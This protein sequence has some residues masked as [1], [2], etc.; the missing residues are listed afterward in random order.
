MGT[1]ARQG[2][3]SALLTA[4][5]INT[6]AGLE[7]ALKA[8]SCKWKTSVKEGV[9]YGAAGTETTIASLSGSGTIGGV[10]FASA[11]A[12]ANSKLRLRI[13]YDGETTPRFDCELGT[14]FGYI[15]ADGDLNRDAWTEHWNAGLVYG[16]RCNFIL[17]LPTSFS[18]GAVVKLYRPGSGVNDGVYFSIVRYTPTVTSTL[19][20]SSTQWDSSSNA[21]SYGYV[22]ATTDFLTVARGKSGWIALHILQCEG[23]DSGGSTNLLSYLERDYQI[24]LGAGTFDWT[25]S[26]T[27]DEFLRSYYGNPDMQPGSVPVQN[28]QMYPGGLPGTMNTLAASY[29]YHSVGAIG[30][31]A[32]T[33]GTA[34]TGTIGTVTTGAGVMNGQYRIYFINSGATADFLVFAPDGVVD[35]MGKVG[36]AYSGQLGFTISDGGTHFSA[37][38]GWTIQIGEAAGTL[39]ADAGA[40]TYWARDYLSD[41]GGLRFTNGCIMRWH[42]DGVVTATGCHTWQ[43][44]L[45]YDTAGSSRGNTPNATI[46]STN[47]LKGWWCADQVIASNNTAITSLQDLSDN[48]NTLIASGTPHYF[49]ASGPN[50]KPY[51]HFNGSTDALS[52]HA[53][54]HGVN[55][56]IT[57][58]IV[59][60]T[61]TNSGTQSLMNSSYDATHTAKVLLNNTPKVAAAAGS[62]LAGPAYSTNTW[63]V[64]AVVFNGASSK[65]YVNS[66]SAGATGAAGA[67]NDGGG[68]VLGANYN[69]SGE[70]FTGDIAEA[71]VYSGDLSSDSS[72]A[73]LMNYLGTKYGVT[74][75]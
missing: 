59:C 55:Q 71:G 35:G 14:L 31:P 57:K 11:E 41:L 23:F 32:K 45:W 21:T 65:I 54:D 24:D 9:S 38:E 69:I 48:G 13:Y 64:I 20:L 63:M 2:G 16:G 6:P 36:T 68:T 46:T 74:I 18:N 62:T 19:R 47:V 26:G 27:E 33:S 25:S 50:G 39:V 17:R 58:F 4:D 40:K 72:L 22:D 3:G 12:T 53:G 70:F 37:G 51:I 1:L 49:S 75:S 34:G 43:T 73:N 28:R 42:W 30:T 15:A 5:A 66:T 52:H 61:S 8:G 56:A 67:Q 7:Y 10:W 60:R 29:F 44:T